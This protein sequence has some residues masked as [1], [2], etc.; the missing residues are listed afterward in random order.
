MISSQQSDAPQP[1]TGLHVESSHRQSEALIE[2]ENRMTR[3]IDLLPEIVFE[4]DAD[5]NLVFLNKAW[6]TTIGLPVD[7]CLGHPLEDFV[8]AEY[9]DACRSLMKESSHAEGGRATIRVRHADGGLLWME[10]SVSRLQ[11]HGVVGALHDVTVRKTL[12]DKLAKLSLVASFTDNPVIITDHLGRTRWVNYAFINFT[13]HTL[14]DMAGKKPGEVLQGPDTDPDT[15]ANVRKWL[16]EGRSF[17]VELLN[18]TPSGETFWNHMQITPIRDDQ[19]NIEHFIAIET[20]STQL[21]RAKQE[22]QAAKEIAEAANDAQNRFLA[23]ISH[24]MRTP[25]N[26]ILGSAELGLSSDALST[27]LRMRF[28]TIDT[29]GEI[30]LRF[31]SDLLDISK[32]E[33]G[34]F[35]CERIPFNLRE[36]FEDALMPVAAHARAKGLDFTFEFDGSL[37]ATILG[38]PGRLRQIVINL[39]E[40]AVKFTEQGGLRVEVSQI[41]PPGPESKARLGIRVS[42]TGAGIPVEAQTRIFHR[43]EQGDSS[44]TRRKG[45]AGLGLSIVKSLADALGGEVGLRSNP[46]EGSEFSVILPIEQAIPAS[47]PSMGEHLRDFTRSFPQRDTPIKVLVAE[48]NQI[49]FELLEILL[50]STGFQVS[51]ANHG[52]EAVAAAGGADLILMDIE[53]PEIDGLEATRRIRTLEQHEGRARVP[54]IALTAHALK[55]FKEVCMEAGCSGYL[56]KPIRMDALLAEIKAT[57]DSRLAGEV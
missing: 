49:N 37:P 20:N 16:Q 56:T 5:G 27:D 10:M 1:G 31:I 50:V 24:E 47:Q 53:M 14:E 17:D 34:Q 8:P 43:F 13:G 41:T 25:L 28:Q 40:N 22:L 51:R 9:H 15:V 7:A 55:G 35:D 48:D 54:I 23:T 52:G 4:T 30:L 26:A 19:G 11:G 3:R 2:A 38:D 6:N 44:I 36:C 45:G 21:R 57:F 46:G 33:A 12:D 39:A 29:N 42:D 32:I 18:Y